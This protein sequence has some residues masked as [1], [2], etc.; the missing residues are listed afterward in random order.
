MEKVERRK[1]VNVES[2]DQ[3]QRGTG[4]K[5]TIQTRR[6]SRKEGTSKQNTL[7]EGLC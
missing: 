1:E 5:Y 4:H 6:V 3:V 7:M 2:E